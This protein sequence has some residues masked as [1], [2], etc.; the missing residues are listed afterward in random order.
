MLENFS[1]EWE[2]RVEILPIKIM[3]I[4]DFHIIQR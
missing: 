2:S 4:E 1:N 3:M